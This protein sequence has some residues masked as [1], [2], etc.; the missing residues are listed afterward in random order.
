MRNT[1]RAKMPP[2]L[3]AKQFAPFAA[4]GGL[5]KALE[6]KR[7]EL[8]FV[9]RKVL[10]EEAAE[11]LDRT[12]RSLRP[13]ETV[14]AVHYR[15]GEYLRTEGEVRQISAAEKSLMVG[16]EKICFENLWRLE[17]LGA[18]GGTDEESISSHKKD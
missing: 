14:A 17:R 10:S 18:D 1:V 9:S 2:S 3:R 15:L 6:E 11:E 13:G 5:E 8:A 16:E 4:L 12:L 7:R